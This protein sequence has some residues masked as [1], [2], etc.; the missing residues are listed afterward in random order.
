AP[1]PRDRVRFPFATTVSRSR[2][3]RQRVV[4]A[5]TSRSTLV[6]VSFPSS[7]GEASLAPLA[8]LPPGGLPSP[9]RTAPLGLP[10]PGPAA[11]GQAGRESRF[12]PPSRAGCRREHPPSVPAPPGTG[13]VWSGLPRFEEEMVGGGAELRGVGVPL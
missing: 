13:P 9:R 12:P 3:V 11:A 10:A 2:Q 7:V 4:A 1:R 8:P 6:R 5:R